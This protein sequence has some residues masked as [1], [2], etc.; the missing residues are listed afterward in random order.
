MSGGSWQTCL[1]KDKPFVAHAVPHS[2]W[3]GFLPYAWVPALGSNLTE[4][5]EVVNPF[6]L[7]A[8]ITCGYAKHMLPRSFLLFHLR[9]KIL[10]LLLSCQSRFNHTKAPAVAPSDCAPKEEHR[11][12]GQGWGSG[13]SS[14][15]PPSVKR[16]PP[17]CSDPR[18][19]SLMHPKER[20]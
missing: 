14:P 15:N 3:L 5:I 13:P 9:K 6:I 10:S 8:S 7:V 17:P 4:R 19:R 11:A 20:H 16:P 12:E 1:L 18:K 2:S